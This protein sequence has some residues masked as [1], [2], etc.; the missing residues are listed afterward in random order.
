[1]LAY[2]I[3]IPVYTSGSGGDISG[4]ESVILIYWMISIA[5]C[6]PHFFELDI[7]SDIDLQPFR[8]ACILIACILFGWLML[9]FII[10]YRIFCFLKR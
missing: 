9:P 8:F 7:N 1:M 10:L 2:P 4:L 3:F 6:I 5:L